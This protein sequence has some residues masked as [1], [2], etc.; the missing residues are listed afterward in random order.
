MPELPEVLR[1]L[2][3]DS[4]RQLRDGVAQYKKV[5]YAS[6]LGAES[7]VLTDLI[8]T[9]VPQIEIFTVDT[10]RLYPQT[11]DLIERLQRRYGRLLKIYYPSAGAVESWVAGNGINGFRDGLQQRLG[12][13]AVRKVEP[14]RR[15]ISGF[16]A[17]ISGIRAE[18]SASR[19]LAQALEWDPANGLHKLSPLLAWSGRDVWRYIHAMRLPYH[20]LHD[21]GFPSIGCAPCTRAVPAGADPRS[22]R[23]WWERAESRECGLH[24]RRAAVEQ[25]AQA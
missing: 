21:A 16:A 25:A 2:V 17:W 5:C 19:A 24:P 4:I 15:A 20:E 8:W 14:F 6:S 12:C 3:T 10:G 13:C 7:M 23:W 11:H 18:Q 1:D 9:H 22:G